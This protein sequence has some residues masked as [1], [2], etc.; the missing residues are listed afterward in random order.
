MEKVLADTCIFI[1]IFRGN[2]QLYQD[3]FK[4]KIAVSSIY[5]KLSIM[6]I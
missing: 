2:R 3:L 6:D 4:Q 1:D 5:K